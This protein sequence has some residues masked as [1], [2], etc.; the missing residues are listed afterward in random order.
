MVADVAIVDAVDA[1][2]AIVDAPGPP[3]GAT[4]GLVCASAWCVR[5]PG[6]CGVCGAG[7]PCGCP[8]VGML[9][10]LRIHWALLVGAEIGMQGS[11]ACR[12]LIELS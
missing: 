2:D 4:R 7:L 6:V 1:V 5:R 10:M 11:G 3:R 8:Q 9:G 12:T